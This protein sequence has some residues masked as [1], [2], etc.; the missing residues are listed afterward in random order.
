MRHGGLG[1]R[2][3]V[4][5]CGSDRVIGSAGGPSC[6][7]SNEVPPPTRSSRWRESIGP[8]KLTR[9]LQFGVGWRGW[10][11]RFPGG[12]ESELGDLPLQLIVE[13]AGR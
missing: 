1:S 9:N 6:D 5:S 3:G 7:R 13:F 8:A 10:R 11:L 12:R 2:R 4:A